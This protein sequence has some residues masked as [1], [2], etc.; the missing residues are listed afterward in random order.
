L[1]T[2]V[3]GHFL[4]RDERMTPL[5]ATGALCGLI[6]VFALIGPQFAAGT[7]GVMLAEFAVLGAAVSYA[8][9]S[10]YGRRFRRLGVSPIA[11]AAGQ[12]TASSLML[13]PIAL[14]VDRPWTLPPPGLATWAAIAGLAS[15]STALGYVLYFR[16]LAGAGAANVVLVTLL[17]PASSILLGAAFLGERLEP[18][19][20]LGLALIAA[21]LACIDGRLPRALRTPGRA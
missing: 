20:L 21:G 11:A 16:I 4:T 13:V 17:A 14:L 7:G 15:L 1:F 5:R 18:R 9:A 12:V 19:H 8:L 3:A 10:L 6:G 2:V